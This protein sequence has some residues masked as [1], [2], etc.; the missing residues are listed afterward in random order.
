MKKLLP[1]TLVLCLISTLFFI[2]PVSADT[3]TENDGQFEYMIWEDGNVASIIRYI[4]NN[5]HVVIPSQ[6]KGNTV[7][8]I[9]QDAFRGNTTLES[10]VIPDTVT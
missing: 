6:Y 8:R 4:G 9:E 7:T 2:L 1:L 5:T 3:V 10:V